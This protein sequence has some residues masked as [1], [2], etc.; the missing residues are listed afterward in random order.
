MPKLLKLQV[1]DYQF[2]P[3]P[4]LHHQHQGT[5]TTTIQFLMLK[6]CNKIHH[7]TAFVDNCTSLKSCIII[8]SLNKTHHTHILS[9]YLS[10]TPSLSITGTLHPELKAAVDIHIL[11]LTV[12]FPQ[13]LI[14][15]S[16]PDCC[17][18]ISFYD[19]NACTKELVMHV[20]LWYIVYIYTLIKNVRTIVTIN[21]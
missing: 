14:H 3:L 8:Q 6:S 13:P 15:Q 7:I 9:L 17:V 21:V 19:I 18:Q 12:I 20:I 5:H 11:T 2:L 1:M 4:L 10:T 16:I